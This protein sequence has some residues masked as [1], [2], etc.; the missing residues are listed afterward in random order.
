MAKSLVWFRNDLRLAD[1]P[2][3]ATAIDEGE[4][5]LVFVLDP[6]AKWG[7]ASLWW[8]HHSLA[9]LQ[10]DC[11]KCGAMLVIRRGN[12]TTIIPQLAAEIGA[13]TVHA[14]RAHEPWLRV[15]DRAV[16]A[17]LKAKNIRFHRVRSALLFAPEQIATKTGGAYGVYTPFSKACFAAYS[18][19][20]PIAEPKRI[21]GIEGV[22][23]ENLDDWD[24]L[25][26][27]PNWAGG[28]RAA[29][30]PG[31]AGAQ[32]RLAD[33]L[34]SGL[35]TYDQNR[36]LPGQ[37]GTSMLS[38][39][40]HWGEIGIDAVW[41]ATDA[42]PTKHK[43]GKQ[44]FLKELLW[45][46]FS[47]YLLWHH[48]KLDSEPMNPRFAAMPWRRVPA[49]LQAWQRGQTGIPI[50]DAG[51]RQL[52]QTGWM[53]NRV[54]MITG[55]FLVKHLLIPWQDGEAWFWDC[56]CEADHAANAASWQW[57]AGCGADAA[58]YFRVF[59]PVLQG[60]KFDPE[61]D[62]VRRYVP[63]LGALPAKHIHNPWEAPDD[64]L[65]A[66]GVTLGKT[67][68]RPLVD[69]REGR[70]RALAAFETIKASA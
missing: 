45:R 51:M 8:L 41:R 28:L 34:K 63:E 69:L 13:E 3:L 27:K 53:H 39:H 7:G 35:E 67:Y 30:Q 1:N 62:Y 10:A 55:S 57:V 14:G 70:D 31:E 48:P 44:T 11:T 32:K 60:W 24:L 17:A 4:V 64:V 16:D 54:R 23:S 2:V 5:L 59:N 25:P 42:T 40:L 18:Q 9:S 36:N 46:E 50:V 66:A 6:A 38:P 29:W 37:G 47:A 56:L 68:P 15:V 21:S 26:T 20:E 58:P 52:W 61:G 33:F 19:R 49:E 65:D 22:K 12:A 43:I